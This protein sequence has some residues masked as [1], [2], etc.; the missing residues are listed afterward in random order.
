LNEFGNGGASATWFNAGMRPDAAAGG[1]NP[2]ASTA[3]AEPAD[4]RPDRSRT[5]EARALL[6]GAVAACALFFLLLGGGWM[7][8]T[9]SLHL[10]GRGHVPRSPQA[11]QEPRVPDTREAHRA[12]WIVYE[13]D[14]GLNCTYVPFDNLSEIFGDPRTALCPSV[15]LKQQEHRHTG[16]SWGRSR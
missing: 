1:W 12:G 8:G 5:R 14:D 10:V 11:E 15:A 2:A 6:A 13:L 16:F 7:I 3:A 9:R 4:G